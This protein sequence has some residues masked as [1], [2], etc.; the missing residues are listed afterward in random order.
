MVHAT[1][2]PQSIAHITCSFCVS[3]A[4]RAGTYFGMVCSHA[5]GKNTADDAVGSV[6]NAHVERARVRARLGFCIAH[7][8][9]S[10]ASLRPPERVTEISI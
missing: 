3:F 10:D 6:A 7:K 4:P 5:F 1:G 9:K 8:R 2:D